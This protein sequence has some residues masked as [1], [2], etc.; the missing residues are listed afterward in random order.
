MHVSSCA[1]ADFVQDSTAP[2][3]DNGDRRASVASQ[4]AARDTEP[5][6]DGAANE[7]TNTADAANTNG[8]PGQMGF[9][10]PNQGSF[11]G[12]SFNGMGQMNGM[13]NMMGNG[14]WNGMNPMGMIPFAFVVPG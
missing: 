5:P 7:N 2:Q 9:G 12:M 8:T 11:N 4:S 14:N 3:D 10:F 6:A 13:S 1:V